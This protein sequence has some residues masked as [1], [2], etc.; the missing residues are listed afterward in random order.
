MEIFSPLP[1]E[2][3]PTPDTSNTLSV[4]GEL[5]L[6]P[7]LNVVRVRVFLQEKT[8]DRLLVVLHAGA[9]IPNIHRCSHLSGLL[10]S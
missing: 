8:N 4:I 9:K 7:P 5:R 10:L 2:L 1:N 6:K 3:T